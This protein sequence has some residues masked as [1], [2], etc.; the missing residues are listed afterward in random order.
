M[1]SAMAGF[2]QRA[3]R[4]KLSSRIESSQTPPW[5]RP[6]TVSSGEGVWNSLVKA[7]S[8]SGSPAKPTRIYMS[9]TRRA[10]QPAKPGLRAT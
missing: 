10:R 4:H 6:D 7:K 2:F 1:A 5:S 3:K 9:L 8:S